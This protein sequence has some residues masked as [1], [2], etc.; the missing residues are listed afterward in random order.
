MSKKTDSTLL[1]PGPDGWEL[2]QGTREQGFSSVLENGADCPPLASEMGKLP[3]GH[4]VMAFPIREALA[5]PFKAQTDDAS[6]FEDLASMQMEKIGIRPDPDAG[7]LTDVFSAG[8]SEG[9]TTLLSVVL[10]PPSVETMPPR[11]PRAFDISARL[12]PMEQNAVTLWCELGRWVFAVT[13][14]GYLTYFQSLSGTGITEDAVRDVRLALNQLRLQGVPINVE[15]AC[16]WLSS[17][18]AEDPSEA[19]ANDFGQALGVEVEITRKPSPI[20]P[21]PLSKL[22]PADVRAEQRRKAESTKRNVG[23]AALILLYLGLAGYLG[24][25]YWLLDQEVKKQ[26]AGLEAMRYEYG[27][28]GIFNDQWDQLAPVVD[29]RHWPLTVLQRSASSITPGQDLR[30][31]VFDATFDQITIRGEAADIKLTS[32]YAGKLRRSL[33][34]YKWSIPP[35]EPDAKTNRWKFNYEGL[36]EG[37]DTSL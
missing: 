19:M 10:A 32:A 12:F 21:S 33:S 28:I 4:L 5:I 25:D 3:S 31:K 27:D 37:S 22:V 29:S 35:A 15:K 17:D 9:E 24:Y 20:L 7:C 34:D 16:V 30:F 36:I 8:N 6:L 13:Q 2:W 23:I 1:I 11:A 14:R 26:N 18:R